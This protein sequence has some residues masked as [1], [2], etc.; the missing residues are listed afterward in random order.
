V[1]NTDNY[2][3]G[4]TLK[5]KE[6]LEKY[7]ENNPL[8]EEFENE[9]IIF[10]RV[11]RTDVKAEHPLHLVFVPKQVKKEFSSYG[12]G[13]HVYLSEQE[14]TFFIE[15]KTE[16]GHPNSFLSELEVN[17]TYWDVMDQIID[18][19]TQILMEM[20]ELRLKF[21]VGE[22]KIKTF[23]RAKQYCKRIQEAL[24]KFPD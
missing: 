1:T 14:D 18:K 13:I 15:A 2:S 22:K 17:A 21:V 24:K 3:G 19:V 5:L 6:L 20:P 10:V 9:E 11:S 23:N 4:A 12:H 16:L 7:F 8:N